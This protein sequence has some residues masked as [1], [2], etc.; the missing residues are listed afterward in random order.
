MVRHQ[1]RNG[2][3]ALVVQVRPSGD[4]FYPSRLAPWS[5][6]LTGEQ[7]VAPR[8][9]YDP[10]HF[11]INATHDRNMEFHAWL[12]PFRTISHVRFSSVADNN[13]AKVKPEWTYKY[14]NTVYLNPGIPAVRKYLTRVVMEIAEKY[15]V[16]GI[17]FD[18]YFYPYQ[19]SGS[20]LNDEAA[21]EQ[22]PDGYKDIHAWRRHNIDLF[23]KQVSDSLKSIRPEV[24]FGISPVGI[25]RNK[26]DDP[27]GS[28][29]RARFTSYDGLYADVRKWLQ[30][31]WLDY[32]APQLYWSNRH[33]RASYDAL[34]PWWAQNSF[35]RHL[36]IGQAVY[37]LKDEASS[38]WENPTQL[39]YQLNL[40]RRHDQVK[41]S[42]FYS[43]NSFRDNPHKI[44]DLLRNDRFRHPALIPSMSWKDS[45]P[46]LAPRQLVAEEKANQ[47]R[48][49]WTEPDTARDQETASY[50]VV[51]RFDS[52][53]NPDLNRPDRIISIQKEKIFVDRDIENGRPYTYLV[54][55]VDRLHNESRT[56]AAVR[57][58]R[59]ET[60]GKP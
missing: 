27:L 41:G 8:P 37:K 15:D 5:E 33:P 28:N 57:L 30:E 55:A 16:D 4:A 45:I 2:M 38:Y 24:K 48:L 25:W 20:T 29:S 7:G 44:E 17:H 56:C 1:R 59:R 14:G 47:I 49:R 46:P 26:Q 31:G 35:G 52:S 9:Y 42:I 13:V 32:V 36:Y 34:L 54:T 53:E 40:N 10:L 22:Y 51:Y 19:Q 21:F 43:A 60:K 6:Y 18:D 11:M 12:N 23:I 3:N 39:P 58:G 50:Y